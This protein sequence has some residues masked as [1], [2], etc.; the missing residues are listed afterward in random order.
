MTTIACVHLSFKMCRCPLVGTS[1]DLESQRKGREFVM[2][3]FPTAV[4]HFDLSNKK[5]LCDC[6]KNRNFAVDFTYINFSFP[7]ISI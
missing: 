3:I 6:G 7:K 4:K 2:N 1:K 5:K